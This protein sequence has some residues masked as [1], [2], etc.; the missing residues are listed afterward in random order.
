M[1]VKRPNLAGVAIPQLRLDEGF[2]VAAIGLFDDD[3][4]LHLGTAQLPETRGHE[5]RQ[6]EQR[7]DGGQR[8][9]A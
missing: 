3:G 1:R 9:H 8:C 2:L 5:Q 7:G 6:H 4:A